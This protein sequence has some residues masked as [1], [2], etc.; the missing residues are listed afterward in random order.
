M[1]KK[2]SE[3]LCFLRCT[4]YSILRLKRKEKENNKRI[5]GTRSRLRA[6]EVETNLTPALTLVIFLFPNKH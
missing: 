4:M 1:C 2:S 3:P 5:T 6:W